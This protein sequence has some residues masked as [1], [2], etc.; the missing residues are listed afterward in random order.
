M[1]PT[2]TPIQTLPRIV[3]FVVSVDQHETQR[4]DENC[5]LTP[6]RVL[7]LNGN[8]DHWTTRPLAMVTGETLQ[9]H[10]DGPAAP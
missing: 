8:W 1:V 2:P 7:V 9:P 6:G 4:G 5:S 3:S 10:G